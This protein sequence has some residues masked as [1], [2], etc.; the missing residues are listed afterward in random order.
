MV[1]TGPVGLFLEVQPGGQWDSEASRLLSP[2]WL[3]PR[4]AMIGWQKVEQLLGSS[5]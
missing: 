3:G 4:T 2:P 5:S 1:F